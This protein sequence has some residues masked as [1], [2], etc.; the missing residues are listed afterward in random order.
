MVAC[1]LSLAASEIHETSPLYTR[2]AQPAVIPAEVSSLGLFVSVLINGQGPFRMLVDTGCTCSMISPEVAA[3]VEAR[4]VDTGDESDQALNGFGD[5]IALPRVLLDSITVGGVQFEGVMAGVVPLEVQ[6][7]I[8]S[9]ELDG[10]LGYT[11]FSD[12]Y[13]ALDYPGRKLI[14]SQD[15]PLNLQP[16]RAELAVKEHSDVPFVS[17]TLQ[18]E[19][20]SVMVDTGAS[21]R[22]HL[23]SQ[24]TASLDWKVAPRPGML[25]A[26]AGEMG[27][28]QVGRLSGFLELGAVKQFEPVV[29]VGGG[30]AD[31]GTGLLHSFCLVFH[32][33]EDKMWLCSADSGPLL[34]PPVRTIGLSMI[35]YPGGWRVAGVIP[36]S[37]AEEAS[38]RK[39]DLVTEIEGQPSQGWTR[40]ELQ[41][42]MDTHEDV[43]LKVGAAS[44]EREVHLR[45]WSL[46]P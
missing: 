36:N 20:F 29:D 45:V 7:K 22:L 26:V 33:S 13:F 24:A 30:S 4:G 40:D 19:V 21:N 12:L 31:I 37:P 15:W 25:I 5:A 34:S 10:L 41:A 39:D 9:R 14:L 35:A 3:A 32:E 23:Q 38:I 43:T 6:S 11:L 44:V 18:R 42:W 46:V 8:D 27:R 2:I 17:V 1:A 28:E 16:V